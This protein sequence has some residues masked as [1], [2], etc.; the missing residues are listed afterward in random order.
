MKVTKENVSI[1]DMAKLL[2]LSRAQ[3]YRHMN[4]GVFVK[5]TYGCGALPYFT[6]QMQEQNIKVRLTNMGVNGKPC[7]F[8][9]TKT[10]AA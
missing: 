9:N 6:R 10:L 8:Y 7:I 4:N 2:G 1:R 5:P 3:F